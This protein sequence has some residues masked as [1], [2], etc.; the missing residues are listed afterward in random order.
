MINEKQKEMTLQEKIK[1]NPYLKISNC[2]DI[3]DIEYAM[4]SLKELEKQF[5]KANTTILS[6]WAK[7]INKHKRLTK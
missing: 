5:G 7:I 1:Q 3:S 4:D 6:I 2:T